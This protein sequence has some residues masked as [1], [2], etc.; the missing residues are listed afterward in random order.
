MFRAG[1]KNGVIRFL[2]R[3]IIVAIRCSHGGGIIFGGS[4]FGETTK[5]IVALEVLGLDSKL[6]ERRLR[7]CVLEII[8]D[9]LCLRDSS[10]YER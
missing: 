7:N 1:W 8:N 2:G 9:A 3:E 5:L 6:V 10:L 4:I